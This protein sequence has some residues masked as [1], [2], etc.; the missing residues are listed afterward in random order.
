MESATEQGV[1]IRSLEPHTKLVVETVYSFYTIE[2]QEDKNITIVG[3]MLEDGQDR[4]PTPTPAVYVGSMRCRHGDKAI[5]WIKVGKGMLFTTKETIISTSN[6]RSV[7]VTSPD[8]SWSYKI[9]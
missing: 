7:E 9:D 8:G 2:T 6:V 3:G 4:F 5:G 1:D